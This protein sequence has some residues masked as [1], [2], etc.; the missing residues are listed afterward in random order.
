MK[1]LNVWSFRLIVSYHVIASALS[2]R[3][4]LSSAEFETRKYM[5]TSRPHWCRL[6]D[7]AQS[8]GY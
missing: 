2:S 3:L 5:Q 1:D 8:K 7:E 4:L 6:V